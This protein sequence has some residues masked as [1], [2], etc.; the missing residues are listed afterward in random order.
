MFK[1]QQLICKDIK[2]IFSKF[3]GILIFVERAVRDALHKDRFFV[4]V[5][6]TILMFLFNFI[7]L[8]LYL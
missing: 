2:P 5:A 4:I 7:F 8:K 6:R 3:V 1:N